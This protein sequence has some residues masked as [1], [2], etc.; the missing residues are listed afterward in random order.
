[1]KAEPDLAS[2]DA[3][4][5]DATARGGA[6]PERRPPTKLHPLDAVKLSG[7]TARK[8]DFDS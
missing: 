1:M 5:R 2:H 3:A 8:Q 7:V 6:A 4:K